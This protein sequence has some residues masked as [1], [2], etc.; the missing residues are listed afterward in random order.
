LTYQ[1]QGRYTT[2]VLSLLYPNRDWRDAIFHEDHIYPQSEF[3]VRGLKKRGY[4]DARVAS[5][6]SKYNTLGNLE[7]LTDSENLSKNATPFD[8]WIETRD[9]SFQARHL[10]PKLTEYG[11]DSFEEFHDL[12]R[13]AIAAS[14]KAL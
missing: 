3:T 4:G 10:I 11:F 9:N 6:L 13:N 8:T 1:Y 14:L 2:L 12:R 5:Y 7:L